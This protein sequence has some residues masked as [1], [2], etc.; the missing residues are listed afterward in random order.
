MVEVLQMLSFP[1][2]VAGTKN[3]GAILDAFLQHPNVKD[4]FECGLLESKE[5]PWLA[6]S[7]DA[8]A[9]LSL[10]DDDMDTLAVVEMKKRASHQRIAAAERIHARYNSIWIEA[11]IGNDVWNGCTEPDHQ[12]Q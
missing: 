7:P 8:I 12:Y 2:M 3:E 9:I 6:A 11:E 1:D 10:P 4:L 5:V